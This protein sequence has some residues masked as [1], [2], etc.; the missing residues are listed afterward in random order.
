MYNEVCVGVVKRAITNQHAQAHD[1]SIQTL[2]QSLSVM[3]TLHERNLKAR[4][5]TCKGMQRSRDL[6]GAERRQILHESISSSDP[7]NLDGRE[8]VTDSR[9]KSTGTPFT[10]SL[11]D[12]RK[13]VSTAKANFKLHYPSLT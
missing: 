3:S 7:F 8:L 10:V 13:F 2:I 4:L 11:E 9:V 12:L 1:L 5:F 6:V